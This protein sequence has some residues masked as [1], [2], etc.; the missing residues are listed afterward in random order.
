MVEAS[1]SGVI[2]SIKLARLSD[3]H[4][5]RLYNHEMFLVLISVRSKVHTGSINR[6]EG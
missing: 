2:G 1:G 3:I 6:R 4:T 5:D